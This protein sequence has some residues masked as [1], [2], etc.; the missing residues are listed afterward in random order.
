MTKVP[1]K[2]PL[3]LKQ[4]ENPLMKNLGF[5][6]FWSV[7]CV[8]LYLLHRFD[9]VG[10]LMQIPIVSHLLVALVR[11]LFWAFVLILLAVG[12]GTVRVLYSIAADILRS[13]E[14]KN[15]EG[16][17]AEITA[18]LRNE[19]TELRAALEKVIKVKGKNH[20]ETAKIFREIGR[21]LK[22][23]GIYQETERC[24]IYQEA[25]EAHREALGI[26]QQILGPKSHEVARTCR[27]IAEL[28]SGPERGQEKNDYLW[29]AVLI[30]KRWVKMTLSGEDMAG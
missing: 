20:I 1:Q 13:S 3:G 30:E 21:N 18:E 9:P 16:E 6:I 15:S 26:Y 29:R 2:A 4:A 19:N 28:V 17:M 22:R 7:C 23:S 24:R 10:L 11:V 27:H 14:K 12:V 25:E 8:C 5:P